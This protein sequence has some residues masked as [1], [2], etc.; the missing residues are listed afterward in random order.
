MKDFLNQGYLEM[1]NKY[2]FASDNTFIVN[3]RLINISERTKIFYDLLNRNYP[4][5]ERIKY[6]LVNYFLF[7]VKKLRGND[8]DS[9]KKR[10]IS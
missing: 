4:Y 7:S 2:Y 6:V 8:K 9:N 3:G 1:F 5:K 10:K